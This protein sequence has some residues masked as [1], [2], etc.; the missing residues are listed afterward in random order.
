MTTTEEQL[1]QAQ[2]FERLKALVDKPYRWIDRKWDAVFWISAAFIV[3]AAC[4]ITLLLFAG[5]WD[6]W[7][8]WK[9]RIW[10]PILTPFALVIIGSALQYIQ[11]LAWRF[12]TGMT[13]TAICLWPLATLGRWLQWGNFVHYP[14]NFVWPTTMVPAGIFADWVLF[15]TKSFILTS[16][17]GSMVFAFAWWVSNYAMIAPFL[18]PAQWMDRVLTVADIQGISFIHSQT[19]EYLRI[20][21]HGTLRSFL[22]ET[23]YVALVFGAT[24]T[25][26][27]YWIGQFIGR[28]LA[29]WPIG[30]F[31][32][33]W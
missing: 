14:L 12:P 3:G 5:D 1:E 17:I 30:R 27:G 21:E 8:D 28:M 2:Q 19:P 20:V 13:Y 23:Q 18:Q 25:V 15:K 33:K 10:W 6:F 9:D 26:A 32:K 11:W 4:D 31:M 7:T 22:G 29:I 16:V 24:V